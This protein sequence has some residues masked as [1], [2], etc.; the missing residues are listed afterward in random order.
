VGSDDW[1]RRDNW[2]PQQGHPFE[3]DPTPRSR[4]D[5]AR[6]VREIQQDNDWKE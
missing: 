5:F 1:T 4:D 2:H 6:K 3:D